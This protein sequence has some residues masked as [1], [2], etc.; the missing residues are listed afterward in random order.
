MA[1]GSIP[2][3][4][5]YPSLLMYLLAPAQAVFDGPVVRGGERH[6]RDDWTPGSRGR[7]V[8]R[9]ACVRPGRGPPGG[10]RRRGRHGARGLLAHGRHGRRSSHSGSRWRSPS[11]CRPARVGGRRGGPRRLG[12]IPGRV[13]AVPLLVGGWGQWRR[14]ARSRRPRAVAFALTSPFVLIHAGAAWGDISRVQRLARAGWLGFEDDRGIA[15][16]VHRPALGGARPVPAGRRRRARRR[17]RQAEPRRSRP[18]SPSCVAYWLYAAPASSAH[19]D[20]YVLPLVPVLGV[21]RR[22]HPELQSA[23]SSPCSWFRFSGRSATHAS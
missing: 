14:L 23:G 22:A 19:F 17:L 12:E 21:L 4:Y 16:R 20:R 1:P 10:R 5:D 9:P 18:R 11:A 7:V 13:L 15:G 2:G 6:R 8:A 3:W